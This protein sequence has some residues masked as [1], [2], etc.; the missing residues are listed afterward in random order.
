MKHAVVDVPTVASWYFAQPQSPAASRLL[1][2]SDQG[3]LLLHAPASLPS[4]LAEHL[5]R[6]RGRNS[7]L[8]QQHINLI[9]ESLQALPILYMP[10]TMLLS[11][12]ITIAIRTGISLHQSLCLTLALAYDIGLYT[13]DERFLSLELPEALKFLIRP[14]EHIV[15]LEEQA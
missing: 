3:T 8:G 2:L 1:A 7:G 13:I 12:A 4:M 14:V 6:I 9:F 5:L 15:F 11:N 10:D